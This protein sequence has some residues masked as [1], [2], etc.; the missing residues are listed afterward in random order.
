MSCSSDDDDVVELEPA[1][2][3]EDE[4][5]QS[6]IY[7]AVAPDTTTEELSPLEGNLTSEVV[8]SRKESRVTYNLWNFIQS[9]LQVLVPVGEPASSSTQPCCPKLDRNM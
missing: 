6:S 1:L 5:P 3:I 7:P 8:S 4:F 9:L 2:R